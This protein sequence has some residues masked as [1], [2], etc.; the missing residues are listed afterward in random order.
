MQ[1]Y[2]R[3]DD[4]LLTS[5]T[6]ERLSVLRSALLAAEAARNSQRLQELVEGEDPSSHSTL[7]SAL[8]SMSAELTVRQQQ[9][10]EVM[11]WT[12]DRGWLRNDANQWKILAMIQRGLSVAEGGGHLMCVRCQK[13]IHDY[14]QCQRHFLSLI[15][16]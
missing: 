10:H 3:D 5:V 9:E 7:L 16:I 13:Q 8:G 6:R 14:G 15:H 11:N 4:A 2:L 1:S 12:R